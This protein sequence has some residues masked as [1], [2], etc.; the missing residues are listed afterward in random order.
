MANRQYY[1]ASTIQVE[2]KIT[3][4]GHALEGKII[5]VTQLS[6]IN[7]LN[8]VAEATFVLAVGYDITKARRNQKSLAH[9]L[10]ATA[11]DQVKIEAVLKPRGRMFVRGDGSVRKWPNKDSCIFRGRIVGMGYTY[12]S[13]KAQLTVS[14]TSWLNDLDYGTLASEDV[15]RG[16]F[17]SMLALVGVQSKRGQAG[18]ALIDNILANAVENKDGDNELWTGILRPMIVAATIS[19]DNSDIDGGQLQGQQS[20]STL[21]DEIEHQFPGTARAEGVLTDSTFHIGN[22]TAYDTLH[23]EFND[24]T[25]IVAGSLPVSGGGSSSVDL[26]KLANDAAAVLLT[27]LGSTTVLNKIIT[28]AQ[29]YEF[30]MISNV[31]AGTM[32]P[33]IAIFP[34]EAVW[35][36]ISPDEY[37]LVTGRGQ[38]PRTLAAVVTIGTSQVQTQ[39]NPEIGGYGINGVYVGRDDGQIKLHQ[40]PRWL[41][42]GEAS[43]DVASNST[44]QYV[45]TNPVAR[46]TAIADQAEVAADQNKVDE[47]SR[48]RTGCLYAKSV[49]ANEA[50]KY[51]HATIR[52]PL[53][54]DICPGSLLRLDG[55]SLSQTG[56]VQEGEGKLYA[57][58]AVV[59]TVIDSQGPHAS[60]EIQVTHLRGENEEDIIPTEHPLYG[61]TWS[62]SPLVKMSAE[63]L[64]A[65]PTL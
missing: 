6:L 21:I 4:K 7:L 61:T 36:V 9:K 18:Y 55:M 20:H 25:N 43:A 60:T 41:F 5:P 56:G 31:E 3:E 1:V 54:F 52:M 11:K 47:L 40:T 65:Q 35:R 16:S 37:V 63:D 34:K 8:R 51:R 23:T 53:R 33:A 45:E 13:G 38:F 30:N 17:D 15:V 59:R 39:N 64:V 2:L 29:R 44:Q 48:L 26:A 12:V 42:A 27:G 10:S 28:F 22:K 14:A 50:F 49:W 19:Q 57:Q 62:G 24:T 46:A 58:V 32:V